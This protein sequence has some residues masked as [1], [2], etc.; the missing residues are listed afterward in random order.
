[1]QPSDRWISHRHYNVGRGD[2]N[3]ANPANSRKV[4]IVGGPPGRD[5]RENRVERTRLTLH[6]LGTVRA[7]IRLVA[8]TP[9]DDLDVVV[10]GK[11]LSELAEDVGGVGG[12]R[13]EVLVDDEDPHRG[14]VYSFGRTRAI[15]VACSRWR[16]RMAD[17]CSSSAARGCS[18]TRSS[19]G[20]PSGRRSTR[21]S[22]TSTR[23]RGR[24]R[25]RRAARLRARRRRRASCIDAAPAGCRG[26]CHR[27]REAARGGVAAGHAIAINALFPHQAARGC[28][29]VRGPARARQHGLRVLRRRL[30]PE[31]D[32]AKDDTP[33]ARD[34]YG[35][36]KLLGE[37]AGTGLRSRSARRSSA[38]SSSALQRP[39]RVVRRPGRE[40]R[41]SGLHRGDLLRPDHAGARRVI[42]RS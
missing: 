21:P 25:P 29:D 17:R 26:Q 15:Y 18:A 1:M 22:A 40:D 42:V 19:A 4:E 8:R 36:S 38:G 23:P 10:A 41:S 32:T 37:V 33:D 13:R 28:A 2:V 35:R 14:N 6:S 34:L 9:G 7:G 3:V 30:P 27:H 5:F 16:T 20:W 24:R 39:A 31:R 11:V 12:V